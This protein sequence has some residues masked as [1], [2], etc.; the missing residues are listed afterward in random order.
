MKDLLD[1]LGG[2]DMSSISVDELE[3]I[4]PNL[5]MNDEILH[6]MPTHLAPYYGKGLRFWQYPNQF[7][8]YLKYL[9]GK[10]IGSYLE[11]GCRWG[12]TFVITSEVLKKRNSD[13]R[14]YCCDLI[15]PSS[16][17]MDYRTHQDFEYLQGSSFS[18]SNSSSLNIDLVLIDGDHSYYGVRK[19]FEIS[20]QFN[21][22]Y[23]VFHD[24]FSDACPGVV[25]FWNEIKVSY[26]NHFEFTD[27]YDS[28]SGNF[29]GIGVIE[30]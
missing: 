23:V 19:D 28:V 9:S 27:Q 4:L 7:S 26:P 11:I 1:I 13:I 5:G 24:I 2:L 21:P 25:Q 15:E 3:A 18:L 29:L 20:L 30:L 17:L 22:K 16:I 14:L 8:K 6:E 10:D 12:G